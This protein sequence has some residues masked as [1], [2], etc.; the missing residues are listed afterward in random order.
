MQQWIIRNLEMDGFQMYTGIRFSIWWKGHLYLS[1]HDAGAD[2]I[3]ALA[4][5]LQTLPL[6]AVS[7]RLKGVFGLFVWD[8]S[9][10]TWQITVDNSG[11]YRVFF[12]TSGHVCTSFFEI[13]AYRSGSIEP[14]RLAQVARVDLTQSTPL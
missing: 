7:H 14:E 8:R 5:Q 12:D 4:Q 11:L 3:N 2:S 1:H 9:D 6:S 10:A 13:A